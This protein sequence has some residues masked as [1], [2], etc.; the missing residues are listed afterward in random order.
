MIVDGLINILAEVDN[1]SAHWAEVAIR[2][3]ILT[4][5]EE[6]SLCIQHDLYKRLRSGDLVA[7]KWFEQVTKEIAASL[8][9]KKLWV[10]NP[11]L[12]TRFQLSQNITSALL[13]IA[14]GNWDSVEKTQPEKISTRQWWGNRIINTVRVLIVGG[15]PLGLLWL[16]QLSPLAL[17]NPISDYAMGGA[18]LW[19]LFTA[20]TTFDPLFAV[21]I[22]A[23]KEIVNLLPIIGKKS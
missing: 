17:G 19:L 4:G 5:L 20:I 12:D 22:D 15:F 18:I 9:A 2:K 16:I 23:L 1:A 3:K 13:S 6:V 10:L 21:K 7:D 14:N 8:R 11:K